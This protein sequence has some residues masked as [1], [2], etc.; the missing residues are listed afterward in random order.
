MGGCWGPLHCLLLSMKI[1][2]MKLGYDP[3]GVTLISVLA[4]DAYDWLIDG[5][6]W[7][8]LALL[9]VSRNVDNPFGAP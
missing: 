7:L 4:E 6:F 2:G 5:G 8:G 9:G 3:S 1:S